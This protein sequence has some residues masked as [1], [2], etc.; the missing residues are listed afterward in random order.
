MDEVMWSR[1]VPVQY[2]ADVAVIGG[3]IA[4]VAAACASA[5]SG[6]RVALVER[7]GVTGGNM[8]T[9]GVDGFCGENRGQGGVFEPSDLYVVSIRNYNRV[10]GK[11]QKR[12]HLENLFV[13]AETPFPRQYLRRIGVQNS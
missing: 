4:G 12:N 5:D 11:K 8:T 10:S 7:F 1:S 3:G 6:A 2:E 13:V 9:G